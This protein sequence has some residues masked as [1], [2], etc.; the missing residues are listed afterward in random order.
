M[1]RQLAI[2][3]LLLFSVSAVAQNLM[4]GVLEDVPKEGGQSPNFRIRIVFK[5]EKSGWAAFQSSCPDE[6]CVRTI[7]ST[8]PSPTEWTI[9]FDGRKLGKL[10]AHKP[11]HYSYYS[12]VGLQDL[13]E[14]Q[15]SVPR[16]G[17]QSTEFGGY[18]ENSV[19]R[20]L[21]AISLPYYTDPDK[22]KPFTPSPS[23]IV[24]LKGGFRQHNPNLCKLT[25]GEESKLEPFRYQDDDVK[26]VKAYQSRGGWAIA[27]LHLDEAVDCQDDEAGFEIYDQWYYITPEAHVVYLDDGMWLVD[28]GDYDNDGASE[29]LFSIDRENRGGYV[30]FY[31]HFRKHSTFE[32]S[33]H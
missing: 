17:K 1:Q 9:A 32:Y 33:F 7:A 19:F 21:V 22:W 27:R 28:A 26:V 29:L 25:A 8:F 10:S 3:A 13:R 30:L 24:A 23:Q 14:Y 16:I 2:V 31:D 15:T 12:E 11:D 5:K 4:L 20:P 6:N 18:V